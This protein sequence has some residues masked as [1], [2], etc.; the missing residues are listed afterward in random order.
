MKL[1]TNTLCFS[2][3]DHLVV[4]SYFLRFTGS[5]ACSDT[6]AH[7]NIQLK[8]CHHAETASYSGMR[9]CWYDAALL[10]VLLLVL[11]LMK[12]PSCIFNEALM[13]CDVVDRNSL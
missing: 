13:G 7:L 6:P 1:Y 11:V 10:L 4:A 3:P 9:R 5:I 12:L 2:A 8:P